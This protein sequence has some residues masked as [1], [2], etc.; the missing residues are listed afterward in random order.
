MKY[1]LPL[2]VVGV[3]ITPN[4]TLYLENPTTINNYNNSS[5]PN[6]VAQLTHTDDHD[7]IQP[8]RVIDIKQVNKLFRPDGDGKFRNLVGT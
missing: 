2:Y 4:L 8:H 5:Q 1:R 7:Y 6:F 3:Y